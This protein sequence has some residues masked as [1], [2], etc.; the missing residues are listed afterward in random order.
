MAEASERAAEL[1]R[2]AAAGVFRLTPFL[3]IGRFA[4]PQRIDWLQA[5]GVTHLLNVGEAAPAAQADLL[6]HAWH[7]VIDFRPL[8]IPRTVAV[9]DELHGMAT[10]RDSSVYVH[11][12][13]GQNRSPTI[14]WLSC[15]AC[16]LDPAS[17]RA[18]IESRTIDAVPGHSA[19][20][21]DELIHTVCNWGRQTL[22]P[23]PR[24]EFLRFT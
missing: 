12:I 8:P 23:H 13:A 14:V 18:E 15:L 10:T 9:L 24:P 3:A 21:Y 6:Q 16:G 4:T 22:M 19:L 2:A 20:I 7:P 5:A 11:C 1:P 17:V